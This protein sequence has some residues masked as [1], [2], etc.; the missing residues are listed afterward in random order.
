MDVVC[1]A[2]VLTLFVPRAE[3]ELVWELACAVRLE[4]NS[5]TKVVEI[6]SPGAWDVR[7]GKA[8]EYCPDGSGTTETISVSVEE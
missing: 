3:V 8:K 6:G 2:V 1:Q 4:G 7:E 5:R